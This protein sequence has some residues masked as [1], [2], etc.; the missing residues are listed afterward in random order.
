[1][2]RKVEVYGGLLDC[3][4]RLL[5]DS[6]PNDTK[7]TGCEIP[8]LE[9]SNISSPIFL[10]DPVH[11]FRQDISQD[12]MLAQLFSAL[13][14]KTDESV[15]AT[16]KALAVSWEFRPNNRHLWNVTTM[17]QDR[18]RIPFIEVESKCRKSALPGYWGIHA[19]MANK[20]V[21][22]AKMKHWPTIQSKIVSSTSSKTLP[23][24]G[25]ASGGSAA[26]EAMERRAVT[27]LEY[28]QN[29]VRM[30]RIC[31]KRDSP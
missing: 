29:R 24:E 23:G 9:L 7:D 22:Y 3:I 25:D 31:H 30:A 10:F 2:I 1:M 4:P 15:D 14:S 6:L 27:N 8:L 26:L 18:T 20:M 17:V 5:S 21:E 11:F 28:F 16:R 19:I 13:G 12:K